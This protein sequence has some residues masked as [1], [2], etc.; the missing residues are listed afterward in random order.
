MELLSDFDVY[1]DT[2]FTLHEIDEKLFKKILL[3]HGEDK[4]LFATDCP[5]RDIKEDVETFKS[6]NLPKET[7]DKILYK[8]ALKLL[9]I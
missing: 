9:G 4:I 2:A 5:W 6:Y 3:S 7:E 8:N 1:F